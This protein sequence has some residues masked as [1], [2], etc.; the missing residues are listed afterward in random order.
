MIALGILLLVCIFLYYE[1][2][3]A[4]GTLLSGIAI[5]LFSFLSPLGH[6]QYFLLELG[7]VAIV[8][9]GFLFLLKKLFKRT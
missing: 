9:G 2:K 4:T 5:V 1:Y 8:I 7:G 6:V 3:I